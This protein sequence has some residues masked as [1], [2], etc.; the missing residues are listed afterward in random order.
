MKQPPTRRFRIAR[1]SRAGSSLRRRLIQAPRPPTHV[2][3]HDT[4]MAVS[5]VFWSAWAL[6]LHQRSYAYA[7]LRISLPVLSVASPLAGMIFGALVFGESPASGPLAILA[8]ATGLAVIVVSV[9]VLARPPAGTSRRHP[10]RSADAA[11][12]RVAAPGRGP[13]AS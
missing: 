5:A 6:I 7:S 3:S 9:T 12:H 4:S 8:E 11:A 1:P 13:G 2:A 10:G